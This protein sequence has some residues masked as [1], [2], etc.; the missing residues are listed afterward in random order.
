MQYNRLKTV[1]ASIKTWY[2]TFKQLWPK[3]VC[4]P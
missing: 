1:S 2:R 4:K 3:N